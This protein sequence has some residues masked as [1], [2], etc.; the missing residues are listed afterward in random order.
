MSVTTDKKK[1]ELLRL[2]QEAGIE[3]HIREL[4][5]DT[6]QAHIDQIGKALRRAG[7]SL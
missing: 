2:L 7:F 6:V 3:R 1:A 5:Q 4:V